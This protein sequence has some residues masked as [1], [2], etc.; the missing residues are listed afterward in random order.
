MTER[1]LHACVAK[2]AQECYQLRHY[3]KY[4]VDDQ[5][6]YTCPL[7]YYQDKCPCTCH[8]EAEEC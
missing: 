3:G 4:P 5:E 1:T 2:D 6:K 8:Q 7:H